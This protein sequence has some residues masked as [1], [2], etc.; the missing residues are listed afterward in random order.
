MVDASISIWVRT[1]KFYEFIR[2]LEDKGYKFQRTNM[3][4][5]PEVIQIYFE[6]IIEKE[7]LVEKLD[8][9]AKFRAGRV[10]NDMHIL[11]FWK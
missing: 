3:S 1:E 5:D 8:E 9:I 6:A 7:E 10:D 4:T 2:F 11:T